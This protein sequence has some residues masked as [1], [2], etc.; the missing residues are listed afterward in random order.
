MQFQTVKFKSLELGSNTS[1]LIKIGTV[2]IK[3]F[4]PMR[5][6]SVYSCSV[7]IHASGFDK[8]L[9]SFFCIVLV[10]EAFSLQK[11]VEMLEEVVVSW[12]EVR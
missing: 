4:L 8:L 2:T 1:L 6:K 11:V 7:K 3:T 5:N 12:Q 10:V 9:E